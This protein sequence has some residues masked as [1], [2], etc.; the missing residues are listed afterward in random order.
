[1][2]T[3]RKEGE[4]MENKIEYLRRLYEDGYNYIATNE[5]GSTY[6]YKS[7]PV[8]ST[9]MWMPKSNSDFKYVVN[10]SWFETRW[11]DKE[12]RRI[13]DLLVVYGADS[14]ELPSIEKATDEDIDDVS[15]PSHYTM[16][17]IE[18]KDFIRD[19]DLNFNR[20]NVIKYVVRAG[21]KDESK[22][23]EDLKKAAQY[24]QFE[25]EYLEG[26]DNGNS[27]SK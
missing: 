8:K 26:Q 17:T 3:I 4:R 19:Q 1:M 14:I 10:D 13:I 18:P 9:H 23:I 5:N 24:L 27:E 20:G 16:G 25:I 7:L 11:H 22:E 21:R 6:A 15:H 2:S 12:V